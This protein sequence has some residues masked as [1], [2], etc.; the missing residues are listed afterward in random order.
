MRLKHLLSV[1]LTLLTLSVGQMWG[2]DPVAS[3]TATDGNEYVVAIYYNSKYYA[4]PN[5]TS[6]GTWAGTEISV[7]GSGYVTTENAPTWKLVE[8]STSGQ[9]YLTYKNGNSTYYLYKNGNSTSNYNIKGSTSSSERNYWSFTAG[10]GANAGKYQVL[11]VGRGS[12][13]TC[14][15]TNN[16]STFQVRNTSGYNIILLEMAPAVPFTVTLMDNSAT[17]TEASVGAGVTLLS[18]PGCTGYTFA[19]WTASWTENQEEWTTT[20]PIIIKA[21]AYSPSADISLYP[22][23][24]KSEG[25][26]TT[27]TKMTAAPKANDVVLLVSEGSTVEGKDKTQSKYIT[28]Q[29]YTSVP[30]GLLPFT[31]ENGYSSGTLSFKNG[32]DYLQYNGSNNELNLSTTK[33]N[34]SSWTVSVNETTGVAT[35][36]N[37]ASTSRVI[38]YNTGSP[39]FACYTSGQQVIQLYKQTSA[40]TTSYISVPTCCTP[41]GSINGSV[42]VSQTSAVVKLASAYAQASNA[43]G[44]QLKVEGSSN[45]DDWTDVDKD[46]LTTSVGVTVNGLTCGTAYTAYLRAKGSGSYCEYGTESSVNFTTSKYSISVADGITNGTIAADKT[47][48]CA[49]ET[50]TLTVTP[51]TTGNGYHLASWRLND[52]DQDINTLSFEM[53]EGNAT[54]SGAF[55]ANNVPMAINITSTDKATVTSSVTS[56]LA[57]TNITLSCTDIDEGY[58]FFGWTVTAGGNPVEVTNPTSATEA[59][60][61]MPAAVTT[62][63]ADIRQMVTVTFK[64]DDANYDSKSTYVGGTVIFPSNPTGLEGYP[65]FI[66]W[67]AAIDGIATSAPTLKSASD[68]ITEDLTYHAVFANA[69][70]PINSYEKVTTTDDMVNNCKYVIAA[71]DAAES[72]YYAATGSLTSNG[73]NLDKENIT[74]KVSNNIVTAP[75]NSEV[76]KATVANSKVQFQNVGNSK[77]MSAVV[78]DNHTNFTLTENTGEQ[79]TYSVSTGAWTFT[80]SSLSNN[81]QIEYYD[82]SGKDYFSYYTAQDAPIY[83]FKQQSA[84]TEW[85]TRT[86]V[87]HTISYNANTQESYTGTLPGS[88]EVIDG[89]DYTVSTAEL[90]GRDGYNFVGWNTDNSASVGLTTIEDVDEDKTLYA[91]WYE[92]PSHK[93]YFYNGT[94]LL[95]GE[96]GTDVLEGG[97]VAYSGE[98]PV[99][100]D[101]GEGASTTFAGWTTA[102]WIGKIAKD[103]ITENTF[104]EG[105]LPKMGESDV[106]YYAVFCKNNAASALFSWEG[107]SSSSLDALDNVTVSGAGTDYTSHSPYLVKLDGTGDYIDITTTAAIGSVS[108]GVKMIGGNTSSSITVKESADGTNFTDVETLVISGAQDAKLTLSTTNA[109]ASTSRVVRLYFNKGANVGVGPITIMGAASKSNYMTTCLLDLG[110]ISGTVGLSQ[111]T[112][113]DNAGKLQATWTM[114]SKDGLADN[115]IIIKIYK[116]GKTPTLVETSV[117]LS[118]DATSY[119][120][121]TAPDYCSEY[122]ATLT[123]V[124]KD[125]SYKDGVEQGKSASNCAISG[126]Y[127]Y[128]TSYSHVAPKSGETVAENSCSSF[129]V[130][131]EGTDGYSLPT[132]VTVSGVTPYSWENGVLSFD[133]ANVTGNVTITINGVEPAAATLSTTESALVF[134]T[135]QQDAVVAAQK[136]RISGVA[137]SAGTITITSPNAGFTVSPTSIEVAAGNLEASEATEITV[138]PVT[139]AVGVFDGN[140]T[141]S[142][143]GALTTVALTMEVK[144]V[145]TVNW[146]VNGTIA[147][148]QKGVSGTALTDIPNDFTEVTDCSVKEFMG[149]ATAPLA[150]AS[151]TAPE[152]MITNTAEMTIS[153]NAD[154][155]AVFATVD[156]E[157][158]YAKVTDA[159]VLTAGDKIVI[160]DGNVGMKAYS[161]GDNNFKEGSITLNSAGDKITALGEGVCEFTLGGT[162]GAWTLY[163]GARYVYAAGTATSSKNY[164]KGKTEKD[165][166]CEWEITISNQTTTVKSKTNTNTPYMRHNS[167]NE[168][169]SCYYSST[170]MNAVTLFRK[171]SAEYSAYVTTCPHITSVTLSAGSADHGSISFEK[172]GSAITSVRTDGG[173]A[174]E[175]DVIASI[176]EGYELTGLTLTS[177]DVTG[178]DK[179]EA[180]TKITIPAGEEGTLTITPTITL[181]PKYSITFANGGADG[182]SD[183][184]PIADQYAGETITLPTNA[185][186]YTDHKF[187]KWKV[188]YGETELDKAVGETFEMPAADVTI[189]AQWLEYVT[190][191]VNAYVNGIKVNTKEVESETALA[192]SEFGTPDNIGGYTFAG[193]ALAEAD[194]DVTSIEMLGASITPEV[195]VESIDIYAVYTR[196]ETGAL[197]TDVITAADLAATSSSYVAFSNVQKNSNAKYAGATAKNGDNIQLNN[198]NNPYKGIISTVSGGILKNISIEWGSASKILDIYA[199]NTAYTEMDNL[200]DNT[201]KGTKVTSF[202]TTGSY[203]F[204]NDYSYIGIRANDGALYLASVSITWQPKNTYYTTAP[205]AVYDVEYA[206]GGGAWKEN[207]GCDDTKVKAGRTYNICTDVPVRDGYNFVKWQIG[208]EDAASTITINANTAITAVW[209]AKPQNNLTY[210]AGT[211]TGSDVVVEDV[212]EGTVVTLKA[213]GSSEGQVNFT[214]SGYDFVGWLKN[215]VLYKAG[216]TFEMPATAVTLT[217]QWK[218]Q[219]VEK[220]SL[221]TDASQ[222]VDGM[223]VVLAYQDADNANKS[224]LNG[225]IPST[226]EYLDVV[227]GTDGVTFD[228]TNKTV[229]YTSGV[230]TLIVEKVEG[231]WTLRKDASNY[232]KENSAKNIAWTTQEYASVWTIN[233]EGENAIITATNPLRFNTG[234][235]RFTTYASGQADIQ[236]YGKATVI[237]GTTSISQIGYVDGDVI[238]LDENATLTVNED[239]APTT[240]IVPQGSTVTVN[241]NKKID[242]NTLIVE[243]GG[244]LD[245]QT[246]GTVKTDETFVIYSTLGKGTGTETSGNAPGS[247]SQIKNANKIAASGNV[248]FELELTQDATATEG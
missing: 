180:L 19:G 68:V 129:S 46:D 152:S 211:G 228:N 103:A 146:Y 163:D 247:S 9:Y 161:S 186:T 238:V 61:T 63:T 83:L 57:N 10:T 23:Y 66:G 71:W 111:L 171:T 70:Q 185:Y 44:Y 62:V 174:V 117:A 235:P 110:G 5:N 192:L 224:A 134:G 123:P 167:G 33:D 37:K 39:R 58:Q 97:A 226:K 193:W 36:T 96:N 17:L 76:W 188:T 245:I 28:T 183:P 53:P 154:Y 126:Q 135:P 127:S 12:N 182:G 222:L 239:I 118:K 13:H 206:L 30:A 144:E 184:T 194:D 89:E 248:F 204:S 244:T 107:G 125:N 86:I 8:G 246:N 131:Y 227:T 20:A 233:F 128:I 139:S 148:T 32:S 47:T 51:S 56:A 191:S 104:Y 42:S 116:D 202:T 214:K 169:F 162:S 187:D 166:E 213:I 137:L 231:G 54:I 203:D 197:K 156:S 11:A 207:E 124:K 151:A 90:G 172:G 142:G 3:A 121:G 120:W 237:S 106:T 114:A 26:G 49:G 230:V 109:F 99:S 179:N 232:L 115:G 72:K 190:C 133:K 160:A 69:Q 212:E 2:A 88:E 234:Y 159:S 221:I 98:A 92:I 75:A 25:S 229:S 67:A 236:L 16:N 141:I 136:F 130:E 79:Y 242:A 113:G 41:L 208:G 108:V 176:D 196:T 59:S 84:Y 95:N 225:D 105:A 52:V 173:V 147:H 177:E 81:K 205:V 48:A 119:V 210:N 31:V 80:T 150:E 45:Y 220:M 34:K 82:D 149:W 55:E 157:A 100:C 40:S 138:T 215:G 50:V 200:W 85:V 14:L 7:N 4:L 198:N 145:Y 181:I 27:W 1:F 94:T 168:L 155:Y 87:K 209:V 158:G 216:E 64:R 189:T 101:E 73:Y 164:M 15:G 218:M 132:S 35:I 112:E 29:S 175:V 6:A 24:T 65:N 38:K 43:D 18:R 22:V 219:N 74:S 77:Y 170:N 241:D 21:G 143:G 102:K 140:I 199:S 165:D 78:N 240:M 178:A 153:G 223:E 217:A 93:V 60:F 122:Y 195:G 91:I 243:R 201:K